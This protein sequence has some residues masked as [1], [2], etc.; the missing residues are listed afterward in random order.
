M[1][2]SGPSNSQSPRSGFGGAQRG[3]R[4]RTVTVEV[5][6]KKVSLLDRKKALTGGAVAP[7]QAR[8]KELVKSASG[9]TDSEV[10]ARMQA[11]KKAS[12]TPPRQERRVS[13]EL[14]EDERQEPKEVSSPSSDEVVQSEA[15]H[16][17]REPCPSSKPEEG[18]REERVRLENPAR[19]PDRRPG[20]PGKDGRVVST[21]RVPMSRRA[22][23]PVS[24]KRTAPVILRAAS[25]GPSPQQVAREKE[26]ARKKAEETSTSSSRS[27]DK[28]RRDAPFSSGAGRA[29]ALFLSGKDSHSRPA[30]ARKV[31]ED[32]DRNET[33]RT[34]RT[35]METPRRL[36]KRVLT[37]FMDD[38]E[39]TRFRSEA[40]FKRAL[41]K[42]SG[43]AK[44]EAAKVIRDVVIPDTITVGELSSRMA[45]SSALVIKSLMKLGILASM[46]QVIDGDT[47]ELICVEFGH[48]PKRTSEEDLEMGV[49]RAEDRPEDMLPRPAIITVMG[50]VDHGKTSLL[51][52]LRKTDVI[53]T[54]FGG[55]TQHIGAYQI[56]TPF[57]DARITF[58]DTPGHAAFSE[59]R[60][61]G[62]NVT[63]IVV[64]VIAA[65]DSV[66]AQTVEAIAHAK[67]AG[68]TMIVA[69]NKIDKP[70]AD[71]QRIRTELLNQGVVLEEYGGDVLAVE[72]SAKQGANLD[73]L[74]E[75]IL[76]Q[77][78]ILELKANPEGPAEGTVIEASVAKGRGIVATVLVQKGTLKPGDIFVA[79]T[80]FGR[81]KTMQDFRGQKVTY[82]GPSC[83]VG[84]LGF[85]G[86]PRA[87]DS[88]LV[89]ESEQKAREIAE[90]R[91]QVRHEKEMVAIRPMSAEQMMSQIA[92]DEEKVFNIVLKADTHGSLEA[93]TNNLSKLSV[94]NVTTKVVHGG[95]GDIN[96][97]DA[98][99]AK[100]SQASLIGFNVRATPQA[101]VLAHRE[102]VSISYYTIVYELFE[103]VEKRMRGLLA[104]KFE[105]NVLGQAE[106]RVVFSKGK[107]T[108]IAG[109][110][111]R[112][113]LIRRSN[114]Q[115]RVLRGNE[116]I[117]TGRIDTMKHEK[118]DIKESREGHE[119]GIILDGFNDLKVGDILECF[120]VV[121]VRSE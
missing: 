9:L 58:L 53:S 46:N 59:M 111:V 3:S 70:T 57:S 12:Q 25:Y 10:D 99:L 66:N 67:A 43:V 91:R 109:C 8:A 86:V 118:D 11:L 107:V 49:R 50:H 37:R 17:E 76:L 62:A 1:T 13:S 72:I 94:E 114:S 19:M 60:A 85:N 31:L 117:F 81:V 103:S 71:P 41:K 84:V 30:K 87:G 75:T 22:A 48:R 54:E 35:T 93:I 74:V 38:E 108:K 115:I 23:E 27:N 95:V 100:A 24:P 52:A 5:R 90:H 83:P 55:I 29:D 112:S 121:E 26:L 89:V 16:L 77:A 69:I 20:A 78:E 28:P 56:I 64:L 98:M 79:G 36:T 106:L 104:P 47:A 14:S 33:S 44:T 40:S 68:A 80:E 61:R 45:V 15:S 105:E 113:G 4:A 65:D 102:G 82:A 96:E 120:E 21:R 88:F 34:K 119:C 97:T 116:T 63:D 51:D 7:D 42:R 39:E 101:K 92:Q 2:D 6:R 73:K 110:Y 32:L 18:E